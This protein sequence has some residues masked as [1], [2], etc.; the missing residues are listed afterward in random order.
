MS[1]PKPPPRHMVDL[2]VLPVCVRGSDSIANASLDVLTSCVVGVVDVA[3]A[4][5]DAA[6]DVDMDGM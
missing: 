3:N 2:F 5:T 1:M 6:V 4:D